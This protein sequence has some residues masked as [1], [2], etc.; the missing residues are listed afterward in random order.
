[1]RL[2]RFFYILSFIN[3]Q[4][5]SSNLPN[6]ESRRLL[7]MYTT[8]LLSLLSLPSALH[9]APHSAI[10]N[11]HQHKR[12]PQAAGGQTVTGKAIYFLT[13]DAQNAVVA[14]AI[15]PDG[16]LGES[17]FTPTGGAGSNSIDGKTSLPAVPDALVGQGALTIAGQNIFAVNAGS[18]TISMLTIS[19]NNPLDV[20]C[21]GQPAPLPGTFPNT[22]AA[23]AKNSLVCAGMT[24][25]QAGISCANFDAQ[26]GIGQMDALRPFDIGQSDPPVG[27][28]N[29]VSHTF[30]S[31]DES[32]LFTTVK[33]DPAVNNTGFLS[34]FAV[35]GEGANG[36]VQIRGA[37]GQ[38]GGQGKGKGNGRP[39]GK[40]KGKNA[41]GNGNANAN[42]PANGNGKANGKGKGK[43]NGKGKGKGK[44]AAK[45]A[46]NANAGLCNTLSTQ[47]TRS[48]PLGTAVLFGSA[49]IPGANP[50]QIF[51]T[52]ASFGAGILSIDPS[53]SA[54]LIANQ[55]IADQKA[56]CWTTISARTG[57]A[58]V[59]DVGINRI[60]EMS[61]QDASIIGQIDLSQIQASA[62]DP[63]LIDLRAAGD[64]VYA[65]SPGNGTTQ[66]AVSVVDTRSKTLVQHALLGNAGA[67]ANSMG[68]AV[69]L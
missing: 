31:E 12:S 68:M 16:S 7:N 36:N 30:F 44:G 33:G 10:N 37:Q 62:G 66:A 43:V 8:L 27:P 20:Q 13:N 4:H 57:T 53:L 59:T 1:L 24:G 22:V 67:G 60:V 51:A 48:S 65:L 61:L 9:A 39:A 15:N 32:T 64:F 19:A 58:F 55:T 34:A 35:N 47:E 21:V 14:M 17:S 29:T 40:G 63:G 56:T 18:N 41:T 5:P 69:L 50:P 11:A 25:S 26:N 54:T 52:D 45:G 42:G 3:H 23:S 6:F 28:T 2:E 38:R 46:A 49:P